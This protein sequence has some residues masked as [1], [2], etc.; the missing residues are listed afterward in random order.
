VNGVDARLKMLPGIV[1]KDDGLMPG[2][3]DHNARERVWELAAGRQLQLQK[4]AGAFEKYPAALHDTTALPHSSP[5]GAIDVS[6]EPA[7]MWM[8]VSPLAFEF[9]DFLISETIRLKF[10]ESFQT[11]LKTERQIADF[12]DAALL[13]RDGI[14]RYVEDRCG[15]DTIGLV[16]GIVRGIVATIGVELPVLASDPSQ[17]TALDAAEVGAD[18]HVPWCGSNHAA[19]AVTDNSQRPLILLLDI[20]VV[21]RCDCSDCRIDVLDFR[22][23]QIVRLEPFAAP[24]ASRCT[25]KA[26]GAAH[27]IVDTGTSEQCIDLLDCSLGAAL[28]QFKHAPYCGREI[29]PAEQFLKRLLVERFG[30]AALLRQPQLHPCDLADA[31]DCTAGELGKLKIN[32]RCRGLRDLAC[33]LSEGTLK[34]ALDFYVLH[35][36]LTQSLQPLIVV[37]K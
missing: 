25:M 5:S 15:S 1:G 11:A 26:E 30:D 24:P 17:S 4:C 35:A 2:V 18:Q 10:P 32:F 29:I 19:A 7:N 9:L 23:F 31:G 33:S 37:E 27:T 20:G 22:L 28:A 21:A 34:L 14:G 6:P 36:I 12:A 3:F 8:R 16:G 13:F